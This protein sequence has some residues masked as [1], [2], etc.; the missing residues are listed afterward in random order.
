MQLHVAKV[1]SSVVDGRGTWCSIVPHF[2]FPV[3]DCE[4]FPLCVDFYHLDVSTLACEMM[5][6][7]IIYAAY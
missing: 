5:N 6:L 3:I 1:Q 2:I 4:D 7:I